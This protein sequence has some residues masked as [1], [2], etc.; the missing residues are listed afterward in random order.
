VFGT[1]VS[2]LKRSEACMESPEKPKVLPKT[3]DSE[4]HSPD[5]PVRPETLRVST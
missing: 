5:T 3:G 2:G 1:R 4:I